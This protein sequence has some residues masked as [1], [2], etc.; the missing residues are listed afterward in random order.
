MVK[1]K[2]PSYFSAQDFVKVSP[3]FS[4]VFQITLTNWSVDQIAEI[5]LFFSSVVWGNLGNYSKSRRILI[6]SCAEKCE[7]FFSLYRMKFDL[8]F[9]KLWTILLVWEIRG[10]HHADHVIGH[11]GIDFVE[12]LSQKGLYSFLLEGWSADKLCKYIGPRSGLASHSWSGSH[13][14]DTQMVFLKEFFKKVDFVKISKL[15]KTGKI[16]QGTKS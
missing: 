5:F 3:G 15:T 6:Q 7:G 14:F 12:F 16:S 11:L 8:V 9:R 1:C 13:L 2:K 10:P 4:A